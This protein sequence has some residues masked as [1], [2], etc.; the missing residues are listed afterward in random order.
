MKN[1]ILSLIFSHLTLFVS[2]SG[3]LLAMDPGTAATV[4]AGVGSANYVSNAVSRAIE[5]FKHNDRNSRAEYISR[6]CDVARQLTGGQYNVLIIKEKH[7]NMA[8]FRDIEGQIELRRDV[9]SHFNNT[10][11][12]LST[13]YKLYIFKSGVFVNHKVAEKQGPEHLVYQG[14]YEKSQDGKS[15]TFSSPC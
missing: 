8:Y 7:T 2:S 9:I 10:F 4:N 13:P 11:N 14:N 6:F 12:C 15:I 5:Q 1:K 3:A